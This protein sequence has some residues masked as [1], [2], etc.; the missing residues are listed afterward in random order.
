MKR[1]RPKGRTTGEARGRSR[2]LCVAMPD[3]ELDA[4]RQDAARLGMEVSEYVRQTIRMGRHLT[5]AF[6]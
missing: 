2:R 4:V 1:G 5:R 3:D 6:R